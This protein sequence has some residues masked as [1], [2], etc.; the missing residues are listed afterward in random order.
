MG[1]PGGVGAA[2][3]TYLKA[4]DLRE[5]EIEKLGKSG[6]GR[7][8]LTARLIDA[9]RRGSEHLGQDIDSVG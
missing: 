8:G 4:G 2:S 6:T 5:A 7:P 1:T 3:A 9:K